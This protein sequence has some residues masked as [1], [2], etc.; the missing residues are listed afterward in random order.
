LR[1]EW[2]EFEREE[3]ASKSI[4]L[5]AGLCFTNKGNCQELRFEGITIARI[6]RLFE[7]NQCTFVGVAMNFREENDQLLR[8]NDQPRERPP[9]VTRISTNS[10]IRSLF[11]LLS[12]FLDFLSIKIFA[13]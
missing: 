13:D 3:V 6:C 12:T 9:D 8:G 10:A 7:G 11:P 5:W 4:R 2:C 1:F